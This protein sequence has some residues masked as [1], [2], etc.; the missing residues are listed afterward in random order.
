MKKNCKFTQNLANV[1]NRAAAGL[2]SYGGVVITGIIEACTL[3]ETGYNIAI[4]QT[5]NAPIAI[6][7]AVLNILTAALFI[8]AIKE[9][10]TAKKEQ[11]LL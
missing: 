11:T 1:A 8:N 7:G 2:F 3:T 10:R 6:A 5:F 4:A 9:L